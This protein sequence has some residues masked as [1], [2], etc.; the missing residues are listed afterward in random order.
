[1]EEECMKHLTPERL[2]FFITTFFILVMVVIL[3][4]CN[5]DKDKILSETNS[6]Y[7]DI[8]TVVT[9]PAVSVLIPEKQ[10]EKLAAAEQ[11]YLKAVALLKNTESID[12]D[13]GKVTLKT[14]IECADTILEVIDA[15]DLVGRY[16]AEI[17]AARV[18]IKVLKNHL[19]V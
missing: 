10:M 14:I 9:D 19:S 15:L 5:M 4:G 17:A 2:I 16:Q 18:S 8:K 13:N 11:K 6:I 3:L 1:M 7:L 12:T